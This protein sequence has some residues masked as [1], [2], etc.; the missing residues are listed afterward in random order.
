MWLL[1]II[2]VGETNLTAH[3][4]DIIEGKSA[5]FLHHDGGV[6]KNAQEH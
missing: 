4:K 1:Y 2:V 5:I 3:Y 6:E